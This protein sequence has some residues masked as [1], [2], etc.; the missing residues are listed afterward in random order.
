MKPSGELPD[1][2]PISFGGG[3]AQLDVLMHE[4]AALRGEVVTALASQVAI[5]S[6]GTATVGLLVAAAA[7]LWGEKTGW[8]PG[9]ILLFGVPLVSFLTL[10][11]HHGELVRLLRA[12]LFLN[13]LECDVNAA[14]GRPTVEDLAREAETGRPTGLVLS[15]EQWSDIRKGNDID[16]FNRWAISGV[17]AVLAIGFAVAGYV[18]LERDPAIPDP[19]ALVVALVSGALIVSLWA[20]L[21]SLVRFGNQYR[22]RYRSRTAACPAP[23][24]TA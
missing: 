4:Y 21:T 3:G 1:R 23:P 2:A 6:F 13:H 5:L 22:A 20:W 18:R 19:W 10:A 8:L 11:V 17:F 12:G 14:F 15:W 24:P 9:L 7:T 16:R